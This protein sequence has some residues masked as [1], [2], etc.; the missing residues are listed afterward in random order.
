[1]SY[2]INAP[3]S[4]LA[5]A[6]FTA[7]IPLALLPIAASAQTL[8]TT[9][10]LL[11]TGSRTVTNY[12]AP[13]T[14][15][16]GG[17]VALATNSSQTLWFMYNDPWGITS[18][19]GTMTQTYSGSGAITMAIN[20]SGLPGGGVDAYPMVLY[21]CDEWMDCYQGQP[22]QFPKQLSAMSSLT[23]DINYAL[24]GTITG[25]DIDLLFDEW[26]CNSATPSDSSQCLEVEIL[27]YYS[28]IYFGGG[29]FVKTINQSV[30]LNG[31]PSTFSMD[32]YATSSNVLIYPHTMP[33]LASGNLQMDLLPLLTAGV[34]AFGNSSYKY[35]AGVEL[36]TEFG[37]SST[38]S[39]TLTLNEFQ[40]AQTLGARPSPPTNLNGVVNP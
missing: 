30:T 37:A 23:V 1:M 38:Q 27:P 21:G 26:V 12:S 40:I 35:L 19:S 31:A 4:R 32:V 29:T 16:T 20:L 18:G 14:G 22:P 33:G 15:G 34:S 28:F 24:T 3:T 8:T 36:G 25:S 2:L 13:G 5:R 39:Y 6:F 10:S 17:P 9:D 11:N 7:L